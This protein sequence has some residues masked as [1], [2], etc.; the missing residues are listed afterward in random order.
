MEPEFNTEFY[1]IEKW[2]KS[3]QWYLPMQ[4]KIMLDDWAQKVKKKLELEIK[5]FRFPIEQ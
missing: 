5:R 1:F 2:R 3:H 4:P